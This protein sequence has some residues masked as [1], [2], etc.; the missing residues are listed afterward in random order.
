[1]IN[2]VKTF[3]GIVKKILR[4]LPIN[5]HKKAFLHLGAT[6]T[7]KLAGWS[8]ADSFNISSLWVQENLSFPRAEEES[9]WI[10]KALWTEA[11]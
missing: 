4:M 2:A 10:F 9:W 8:D 1:M 3:A 6:L 7:W 5:K 11:L